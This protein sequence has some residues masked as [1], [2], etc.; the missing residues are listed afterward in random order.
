MEKLVF[1]TVS[2]LLVTVVALFVIK[3]LSQLDKSDVIKVNDVEEI[4]RRK[5]NRSDNIEG[6]LYTCKSR[7]SL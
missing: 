1:V 2:M 4:T 5:C 3:E 6:T 7:Q